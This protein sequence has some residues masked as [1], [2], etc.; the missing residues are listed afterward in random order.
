MAACN[1]LYKKEIFKDIRYPKGKIHEDE[2][3]IH[4]IFYKCRKIAA[5]DKSF[6]FIRYAAIP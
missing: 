2:Y 5:I 6:I 4:R 1:K 3:V